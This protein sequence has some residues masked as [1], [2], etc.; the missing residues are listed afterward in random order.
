MAVDSENGSAIAPVWTNARR[1]AFGQLCAA[2]LARKPIVALVGAAG[3]G[4]ATILRE[5][6]AQAGHNTRLFWLP[7]STGYAEADKAAIAEIFGV[8]AD[9]NLFGNISEVL[10]SEPSVDQ[11]NVMVVEDA[12]DMSDELLAQLA[13][14]TATN[15]DG[16]AVLSLIVSG[17]ETLIE[18][19]DDRTV[20]PNA[21]IVDLPGLT[22]TA[23]G[24]L[25]KRHLG[26]ARTVEDAVV[27]SVHELTG[28]NP[29]QVI[30][31]AAA[32]REMMAARSLTLL[33]EP[34]F[35]E[36]VSE[37]PTAP[38]EQ[39][40]RTLPPDVNTPDQLPNSIS[41]SE[42][43][44]EM[45][46]WAFGLSEE[47]EAEGLDDGTGALALPPSRH[48]PAAAN[49]PDDINKALAEIA[50]RENAQRTTNAAPEA[51]PELPF[52][53]NVRPDQFRHGAEGLAAIMGHDRRLSPV[54]AEKLEVGP[55][56]SAP[57]ELKERV[58][59][60]EEPPRK[61][62]RGVLMIG[63]LAACF[64][65]GAFGWPEIQKRFLDQPVASDAGGA[66]QT[67]VVLPAGPA[68]IF[69]DP[70]SGFNPA[71][72]PV[73]SDGVGIPEPVV[74]DPISGG[75]SIAQ[76]QIA[77]ANP[78][79]V[80]EQNRTASL[81]SAEERRRNLTQAAAEA[82]GRLSDI[83][84]QIAQAERRLA[85]LAGEEDLILSDIATLRNEQVSL[86]EDA[87]T[88][89][90]ELAALAEETEAARAALATVTQDQQAAQAQ[91]AALAAQ[92]SDLS[93][94]IA[95]AEQALAEVTAALNG[96]TGALSA[97]LEAARVND[98]ALATARRELAEIDA[99][100]SDLEARV[101]VLRGEQAA[102]DETVAQGQA[103]V[104][105]LQQNLEET[106]LELETRAADLSALDAQI[107]KSGTQLDAVRAA[108]L[109]AE[110]RRDDAQAA[111][112]QAD[113]TLQ[114]L[115]AA[116]ER[117][118]AVLANVEAEESV[119]K[120]LTDRRAAIEAQLATAQKALASEEARIAA[121]SQDAGRTESALSDLTSE[122]AALETSRT[123]MLRKIDETEVALDASRAELGT[124]AKQVEQAVLQRTAARAQLTETTEA[125][126]AALQ[127]LEAAKASSGQAQT[128]LAALLGERDTLD[129]EVKSLTQQLVDDRARRSEA[130]TTIATT[131][132]KLRDVAA[133]VEEREAALTALD[134]Q[135]IDAEQS[136]TSLTQQAAGLQAE[137]GVLKDQRASA[138][139][140]LEIEETRL[141]DLRAENDALTAT[142]A[143]TEAALEDKLAALS[144][145]ETQLA[146]VTAR[147]QD[148]APKPLP[149]TTANLVARAAGVVDDALLKAPGLD[150]LTEAQADA[151]RVALVDGHCVADALKATTGR[152]NPFTVRALRRLIGACAQ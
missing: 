18:T 40:I 31:L 138:A 113:K 117:R 48:E 59:T 17:E 130:L 46:R 9:E 102:L 26:G 141:A 39:P 151:L 55:P 99:Q 137:L 146:A 149:E 13:G 147:L 86:S 87:A 120:D 111:V 108:A 51:A 16:E 27:E 91:V 5:W 94:E 44:R 88:G 37:V 34:E 10:G 50:A 7:G 22:M 66:T 135:K 136:V 56:M 97:N 35:A 63:G 124:V 131:Q 134:A 150:A 61:R 148:A 62:G 8:A 57:D 38:V 43:P 53:G 49:N 128:Q 81:L 109:E 60:V 93:A 140:A 33:E 82:E 79:Q 123:Q 80:E 107:A 129:A 3:M 89:R 95:E 64:A 92:Q 106:A 15:A 104:L 24:V 112:A 125:Q 25:F 1:G 21:D 42:N 74:D 12:H 45:L 118:G 54:P 77:S 32:S 41:Q 121:A 122:L 101:G 14:L 30:G 78:Y 100:K 110:A 65:A 98:E 58:L 85:T 20:F 4:K 70:V 52:A 115:L 71:P 103:Q 144:Q 68:G 28:G 116:Q 75:P 2:L 126:A 142:S 83:E 84:R 127:D 145:A 76:V 90:N 143:A 119:L 96:Q 29:A 132:S 19:L 105:S 133:L 6:R 152:A 47:D 67:A 36:V 23:T 73:F 11:A 114:E 139:A 72:Q 69:T